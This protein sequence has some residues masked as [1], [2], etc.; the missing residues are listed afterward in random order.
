MGSTVC[1][2]A[3][4][5]ERAFDASPVSDRLATGFAKLGLAL[6]NE[7]GQ[8][9]RVWGVSPTQAQ[10]LLSV[11]NRPRRASELAEELGVGI[12]TVSESAAA[13]EAK[14][15]IVRRTDPAD[16]RAVLFEATSAGRKA[17]AELAGWPDFLAQAIDSLPIE[18]QERLL[19]ITIRL[20]RRLQV[21]G[22]IPVARMCVTCVYF[23]PNVHS[24]PARPHHCAFV[25][26]AFGDAELRIDCD[27]Y[28]AHNG[29]VPVPD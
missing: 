13:A 12:A 25:D 16:A 15:L 2:R 6:K 7:L 26:A 9:S 4:V 3:V 8:L 11:A 21:E 22:R 19:C 28:R 23:R 20:I 24:N 18:D 1:W 17:A 5:A 10:I 14:G 27:D 29:T